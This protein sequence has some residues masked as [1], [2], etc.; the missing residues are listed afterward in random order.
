MPNDF[1]EAYFLVTHGS[2]AARSFAQLQELVALTKTN[3]PHKM[4]GGG[5]L[6]GLASSLAEQLEDFGKA[7][8]PLGYNQI[9]VIPIF[10]MP[11]VHVCQDLPEQVELANRSSS[12][13]FHLTDYFGNHSKISQILAAKFSTFPNYKRILISHGSKL[14]VGNLSFENLAA[15]LN[16]RTAYWSMSPSLEDQIFNLNQQG[17]NQICVIPY[18]LFAGGITEAIA[19]QVSSFTNVKLANLPF[20]PLQIAKMSLEI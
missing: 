11:G 4:I 15:K 12:L 14:T 7:A 6:E 5:C 9:K 19:S 8:L 2:R 13:E 17:I 10:L 20:T 3:N 16:A 18:F 1:S